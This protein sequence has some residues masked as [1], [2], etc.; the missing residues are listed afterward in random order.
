MNAL[1]EPGRAVWLL[2]LVVN[3][4]SAS[5]AGRPDD[6]WAPF[7]LVT[8]ET[9]VATIRLEPELLEHREAIVE[10]V[11][12][13]VTAVRGRAVARE[14][15]AERS[16]EITGRVNATLGF[17]P[18]AIQ[19]AQQQV[20]IAGFLRLMSVYFAEPDELD[21]RV[22]LQ[23]TVKAHLRDGG[24]L[25]G[26]TYDPETDR[27][28]YKWSVE[29]R[30]DFEGLYEAL[31]LKEFPLLLTGPDELSEPLRVD[32]LDTMTTVDVGV[33]LH[34]L[35]EVSIN[36]MLEPHDPHF[37]WFGDGMA[38]AL[39][40]ELLR[41]LE[42]TSDTLEQSTDISRFAHLKGQ[43]NLRYWPGAAYAIESPLESERELSLARYA[44][45]THEATRLIEAHGVDAVRTIMVDAAKLDAMKVDGLIEVINGVTGENM[46]ER[47]A[48]YQSFATVPAGAS[49]YH[50]E[51]MEADAVDDWERAFVNVARL[52]ELALTKEYVPNL[53]YQAAGVL[54]EG[55]HAEAGAEILQ[56]QIKTLRANGAKP[57]EVLQVMTLFVFYAVS[58]DLPSLAYT[59]AETLLRVSPTHLSSMIV[60][61]HWLVEADQ[62][63]E[64]AQLARKVIQDGRLTPPQRRSIDRVLEAVAL[65]EPMEGDSRP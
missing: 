20:M 27:C 64:A 13:F 4:A 29:A 51:A 59:E 5:Q 25:P 22:V 52:S 45:A 55:G 16:D 10:R 35:F 37:R 50:R 38:N 23:D 61:A 14:R 17:E 12:E 39:A 7:D 2:C 43:V 42:M 9:E 44:Y 49:V 3:L 26:F 1:R 63:E 34:E 62:H 47:L 58:V 18:D 28:T 60:W 46:A 32:V 31:K 40:L 11:T 36:L 24:S 21:I 48:Q 41:E 19:A 6:P 57:G 33:W 8:I 30:G 65:A 53:Y 15:F 56:Q 54:A